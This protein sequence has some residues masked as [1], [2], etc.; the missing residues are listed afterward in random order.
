MKER[1]MSGEFFV[2]AMLASFGAGAA[3]MY[4][5]MKDHVR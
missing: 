4:L 1:Y 5:L 3:A 2:L